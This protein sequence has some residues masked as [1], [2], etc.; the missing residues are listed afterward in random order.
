VHVL[1]HFSG[2]NPLSGAAVRLGDV[3][4]NVLD[5]AGGPDAPHTPGTDPDPAKVPGLDQEPDLVGLHVQVFRDLLDRQKTMWDGFVG[6]P[7][8]L[9]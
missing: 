6:R 5:Q 3:V 8:I 9:Y 1:P 7:V 4:L 2:R